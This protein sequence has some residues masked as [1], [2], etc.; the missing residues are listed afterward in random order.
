MMGA[1]VITNSPLNPLIIIVAGLALL[2]GGATCLRAQKRLPLRPKATSPLIEFN[3][4]KTVRARTGDSLTSIA[5]RA[6]VSSAEL[7]RINN[8]P[9]N[10]RLKKGQRIFVSAGQTSR[11]IKETGPAIGQRIRFADGGTLDVDETWKQGAVTWYKRGGVTQSLERAVI[12]IEPR[13]PQNPVLGVVTPARSV[14]AESTGNAQRLEVWI[15]LVGGARF[16]VDDVRETSEGAWYSRAN[17]S[18]FLERDRI[19]RITREDSFTGGRGLRT[20]DW[21]SGN[22]RIDE[23]IKVNG[24]RFG[25]DPYLLF[26][27]IE[28]ESHFRARAVSP[29]GARGLMQLM[30]ATA[31][32]FGV[33]NSFDVAENIKGG[34][35]YLRELMDMFGGQVNL[36]LASYNAGEGAV[37]KY[38]RNVPPYRETREYVKKIGKRY[39]LA[40]REPD[41]DS[42]TSAPRR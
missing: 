13:F 26:C 27:V 33:R 34:T 8:L 32:R 7:A 5:E 35:Q 24:H 2:C 9:L 39:G 11:Q 10:A 37:L 18:V 17:L 20:S 1:K 25:V 41:A 15:F 31:R 3:P 14:T 6:N 29:K 21:S 42:E 28:Q 23:L 22:S 38:G 30:P 36:V 40:V 16:K 12:S 4:Q 19:A